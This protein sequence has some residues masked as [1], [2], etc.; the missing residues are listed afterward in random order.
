MILSAQT[1]RALCDARTV[2]L[3][4]L[5]GPLI[6]PFAE[7]TVHESGTTFGLGPSTYDVRIAED[8]TIRPGAFEL[9]STVERFSMPLDLCA[10]VMDKSSL[11]RQGLTVQN[12]HLDPGWQGFLTL[13]L[14]NHGPHTMELAKGRPI[15]QIKFELLDRPTVQPYAGKYQRQPAGP[16]PARRE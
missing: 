13:E 11:V 2:E 1:I 4:Q 14:V 7:R 6:T 9:A 15:A 8:L 3:F 5:A 12:T 10:T 16:V